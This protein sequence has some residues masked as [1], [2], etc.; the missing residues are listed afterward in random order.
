MRSDGAVKKNHPDYNSY[1]SVP[2]EYK[3]EPQQHKVEYVMSAETDPNSRITFDCG[4][5]KVGGT[6]SI[7]IEN[8][9]ITKVQ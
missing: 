8:L 5:S 4:G 2:L 7:T 1:Y 6:Y 3:T 9:V